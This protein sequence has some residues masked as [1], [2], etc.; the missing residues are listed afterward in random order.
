MVL[1]ELDTLFYWSDIGFTEVRLGVGLV[2]LALFLE[3]KLVEK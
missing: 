3:N 1:K 2:A